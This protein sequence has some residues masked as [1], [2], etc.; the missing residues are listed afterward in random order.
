MRVFFRVS[1]R[2]GIHASMRPLACAH[3]PSRATCRYCTYQME[4]AGAATPPVA[5][6]LAAS[7]SAG[8]PG[9][10]SFE[11]LSAMLAKLSAGGGAAAAAAGDAV[12]LEWAGRKFTVKN[13]RARACLA[14][15]AA[16]LE[17]GQRVGGGEGVD[18]GGVEARLSAYARAVNAFNEARSH[19][20]NAMQGVEVWN[21]GGVELGGGVGAWSW[22]LG[23]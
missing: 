6:L 17:A 21:W 15:A 5:K 8:R 18:D 4:R 22:V 10:R 1:C 19:V 23:A 9:R 3:A 12:Q 7:A 2:G 16:L 20:R 11:E 14:N 13:A